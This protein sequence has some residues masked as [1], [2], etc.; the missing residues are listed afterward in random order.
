MAEGP[1]YSK[2]RIFH[3]DDP[4]PFALQPHRHN[5]FMRYIVTGGAGFIG[6][7]LADTVAPRTLT[8]LLLR[9]YGTSHLA[10]HL[11]VV[12]IDNLATGRRANI[13]HLLDRPRVTFIGEHHGPRPPH[14]GAMAGPAG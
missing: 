8:V 4:E 11:D 14:E 13:E 10:Q 1:A 9:S 3:E 2:R 12:I 7:N 5:L 6:S